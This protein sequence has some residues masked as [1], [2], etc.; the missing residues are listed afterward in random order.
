MT[1]QTEC[2]AK[3]TE[4][5]FDRFEAAARAHGG[6][7]D[8]AVRLM[9]HVLGKMH[10][11]DVVLILRQLADIYEAAATEEAARAAGHQALTAFLASR[12]MKGMAS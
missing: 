6:L 5:A 7:E 8:I 4:A 1:Q 9:D 11:T 2:L 10:V 3:T 12:D